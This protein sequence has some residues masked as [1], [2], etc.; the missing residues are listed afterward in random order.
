MNNI[1]K[2][3][4]LDHRTI[5]PYLTLKNLVIVLGV[6]LFLAFVNKNALIPLSII[7]VF[8]T[9]YL[10]YPFAVGEQNGID[11]LYRILG[12][13]RRN[14]VL[15]RYLWALSMNLGGIVFGLI[16]AL[17]LS[18]ALSLPFVLGEALAMLGGL[19]FIFSLM[20]AFQFPLFFKL[21]YMKAKTVSYLPF[22]VLGGIF[23]VFSSFLDRIPVSFLTNVEK[24]FSDSL[25]FA[26]ILVILLW[27]FLQ[28]ISILFSL[29][30]YEKRDF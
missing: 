19:F 9:I 8:V 6:A 10:S 18:L 2:F 4:E 24:F 14:V 15:G 23:V 30:G 27:G 16:L 28:G 26:I 3:V 5:K 25:G 1:L 13:S 11:P 17:L 12:V 7:S 22:M 29:R 20:Q 21:G